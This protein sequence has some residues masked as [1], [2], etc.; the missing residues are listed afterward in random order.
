MLRIFLLLV[1]ICT[2]CFF[3]YCSDDAA[4]DDGAFVE[5]VVP[6]QDENKVEGAK[7][8]EGVSTQQLLLELAATAE[9]QTELVARLKTRYV[10]ESSTLAQKDE[11]ITVLRA[12]LA[13]AQAEVESVKAHA[14]KVTDEKVSMLTELQ[15]ARGELHQFRANMTWSV[16]YL[17]ERRVEH[18]AN[19]EEFKVRMEKIIQVQEE[20][21]RG[22]SI[23]YDEELYPHLMST[24]AERK[25]VHIYFPSMLL[26]YIC[27]YIS[28]NTSYPC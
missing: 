23:E 20:K 15:H 27:L 1:V 28:A 21:L 8:D 2:N 10:G 5:T 25:Y 4:K 18:F 7:V 11:E 17:E 19:I 26:Y 14:D 12:Q 9:R 3:I 16:R 13:E 22:L 24:I 6:P